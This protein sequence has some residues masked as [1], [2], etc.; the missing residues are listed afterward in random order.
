M[1]R[2]FWIAAVLT[3]PVFLAGMFEIAPLI[4]LL[5]T[6]VVLWAG[7]PLFQRGAASIINRSPNMFTLIAIGTGAAYFY[8]V[9]AAYRGLPVYFEAASVITTLVLLGQVLVDARQKQ[10]RHG[11]Q[12]T[13]QS[14]AEN[15]AAS[16][17]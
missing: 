1:T 12:S 2:R 17:R 7:W 3:T 16:F 6:P 5:A 10:N 9:A 8:S 14:G 4:Q 15:R 11:D 13:V